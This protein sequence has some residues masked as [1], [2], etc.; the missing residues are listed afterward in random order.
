MVAIPA[1][2]ARGVRLPVERQ[3]PIRR[4][5]HQALARVAVFPAV[6]RGEI[7]TLRLVT[8]VR[9]QCV[10]FLE[11]TAKQLEHPIGI[12]RVGGGEQLAARRAYVDALPRAAL[13]AVVC[14]VGEGLKELAV[15]VASSLQP[16]DLVG[17]RHKS[18][19]DLDET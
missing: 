12:E 10:P 5:E 19:C 9:R 11:G 3:V 1:T 4:D 13:T 8:L 2:P 18:R 14:L 17:G 7:G 16:P 6:T 15:C